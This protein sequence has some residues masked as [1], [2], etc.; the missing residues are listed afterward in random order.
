MTINNPEITLEAAVLQYIQHLQ[1]QKKSTITINA[2]TWDL[3]QGLAFFGT[4]CPVSRITL[5]WVG[6]FLK[7]PELLE[8][9]NGQPRSSR[10]VAKTIRI[11]RM[12]LIWSEQQGW[13]ENLPLPKSIPL[14]HSRKAEKVE[15][16]LAC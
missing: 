13:I 8:N 1:E 4:D 14:G 12:F 10:T 16:G 5:A 2:Y 6:R 9:K 3:K 15:E 7:S 11:F